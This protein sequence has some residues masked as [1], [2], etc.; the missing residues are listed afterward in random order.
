MYESC[1]EFLIFCV[2]ACTK[3]G[4]SKFSEVFP[5]AAGAIIVGGP[6]ACSPGK[7]WNFRCSEMQFPAFSED[8]SWKHAGTFIPQ[9]VS[10]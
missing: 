1:Q 2:H 9:I 10:F 6:G 4:S 3:D 8:V 7:F 5:N